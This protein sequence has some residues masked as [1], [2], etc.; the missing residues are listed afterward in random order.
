[1]NKKKMAIIA[2]VV[3]AL[4]IIIVVVIILIPKAKNIKYEVIV[5]SATL[6]TINVNKSKTRKNE[7]VKQQDSYYLVIHEDE[8]EKYY[9]LEV[10]SVSTTKEDIKVVVKKVIGTLNIGSNPKAIIKLDKKP[11]K[12]EVIYR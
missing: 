6:K 10:E 2:G 4:V 3:V 12:V 11:K 8:Q 9:T 5:D 7:I 1:M